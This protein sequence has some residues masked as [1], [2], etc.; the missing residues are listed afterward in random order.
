MPHLDVERTWH[1]HGNEATLHQFSK[2]GMGT[3]LADTQAAGRL[4][5]RQEQLAVVVASVQ[6]I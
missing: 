6:G 5:D 3:V 2:R 1:A 4:A